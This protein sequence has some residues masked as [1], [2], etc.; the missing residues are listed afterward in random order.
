V[1]VL[2]NNFLLKVFYFFPFLLVHLF[3]HVV[4]RDKHSFEIFFFREEVLV[5]L[6]TGL[7]VSAALREHGRSREFL[8]CLF[9]LDVER[10]LQVVDC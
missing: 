5:A 4:T 1:H 2:D 10:D 6:G 9:R 8:L 3:D 7:E